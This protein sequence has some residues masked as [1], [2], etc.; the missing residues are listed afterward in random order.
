[1]DYYADRLGDLAQNEVILPVQFADGHRRA[2]TPEQQLMLAVLNDALHLAVR[3]EP[4]SNHQRKDQWT[5]RAWLAAPRQPG[6]GL[7]VHDV[8]DALELEVN[9]VRARLQAG[10]IAQVPKHMHIAGLGTQRRKMT[11]V[12]HSGVRRQSTPIG[13]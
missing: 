12:R 1:M 7:S 10:T 3:K 4:M 5:A 2:F 8:C 9:W 11:Q 13:F 6:P